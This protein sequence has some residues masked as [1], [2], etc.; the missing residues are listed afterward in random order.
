MATGGG[1]IIQVTSVSSSTGAITL[2]AT[3]YVG[4]LRAQAVPA[5]QDGNAIG[6]LIEHSSIQSEWELVE[7]V[8]THSTLNLTRPAAKV[9]LGTNGPGA[10]VDFSPGGLIVSVVD[11]YENFRHFLLF[12]GGGATINEVVSGPT[13][14][15][16]VAGGTFALN[17]TNRKLRSVKVLGPADGA[18]T[19]NMQ[20]TLPDPDLYEEGDEHYVEKGDSSTFTVTVF[21][22]DTSETGTHVLRRQD[23]FIVAKITGKTSK[24]WERQRGGQQNPTAHGQDIMRAADAGAVRAL[25][26]VTDAAEFTTDRTAADTDT[27]LGR[28]RWQGTSAG[29]FTVPNGLTVG[30]DF[31]I[32]VDHDLASIAP[33]TVERTSGDGNYRLGG[34]IGGRILRPGGI[35]H[36]RVVEDGVYIVGDLDPAP[37]DAQNGG[38]SF[39]LIRGLNQTMSGA[40]LTAWGDDYGLGDFDIGTGSAGVGE[41][42]QMTWAPSATAI[43]LESAARTFAGTSLL[44]GFAGRINAFT[45]PTT[46]ILIW[47]AMNYSAGRGLGL[48]RDIDSTMRFFVM[49][50]TSTDSGMT[51]IAALGRPFAFGAAINRSAGYVHAF[52]DEGFEDREKHFVLNGLTFIVDWTTASVVPRIGSFPD[53]SHSINAEAFAVELRDNVSFANEA[54]ARDQAHAMLSLMRSRGPL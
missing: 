23:Q 11:K 54:D 47:H 6:V 41:D 42:G 9:A 38:A 48:Q 52:F 53:A 37:M 2:S 15:E 31:E 25:Q 3:P 24:K 26:R 10:N 21:G 17:A 51:S 50:N 7:G 33:L 39:S 49:T 44:V 8:Y 46:R 28:L 30:T 16:F 40:V 32:V 34:P 18:L 4:N 45:A 29:R 43:Y 35:A 12:R 19:A 27:N 22:F 5:D 1:D 20:V 13:T 36:V 14:Y